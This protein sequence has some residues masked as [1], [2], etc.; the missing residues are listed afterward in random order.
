MPAPGAGLAS[1]KSTG[2]CERVDGTSPACAPAAGVVTLV[3]ARNPELTPAQV[4]DVLTTTA[5]PPVGGGSA[6]PGYGAIDADAAVRAAFP[7][8]RGGCFP[9]RGTFRF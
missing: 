6:L 8:P 3:R 4:N 7:P 2:G 9:G 5:H 1:A